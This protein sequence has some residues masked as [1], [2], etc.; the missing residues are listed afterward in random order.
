MALVEY[1]NSEPGGT[2]VPELV[3]P[4]QEVYSIKYFYQDSLFHLTLKFLL[5][6]YSTNI[7]GGSTLKITRTGP[8]QKYMFN[9]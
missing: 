5:Q 9:Q 1:A 4:T 7:S 6:F 3:K 8:H 2:C